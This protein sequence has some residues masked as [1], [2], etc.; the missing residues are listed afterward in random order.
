MFAYGGFGIWTYVSTP[1]SLYIFMFT[2]SVLYVRFILEI[3][4]KFGG[5]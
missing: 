3:Y 2:N 4:P 5:C 1:F